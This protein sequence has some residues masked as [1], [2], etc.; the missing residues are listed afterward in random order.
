MMLLL[1]KDLK[2]AVDLHF[3]IYNIKIEIGLYYNIIIKMEFTLN[4]TLLVL[5]ENN[6]LYYWF[7]KNGGYKLKNPYWRLKETWIDNGYFCCK[8]N[9]KRYLFHRV[10]YYAYNQDW[11]IEDSSKD[12]I[13]DHIDRDT[14]NNHISNLRRCNN[15]VNMLNRQFVDNAKGYRIRPNGKFEVFF[16]GKTQGTCDTEDEAHQKYLNVKNEYLKE[17]N[18]VI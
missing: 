2:Q 6:D 1:R 4:D 5:C 17:N 18:I 3:K 7:D 9:N 11:N 15:S 14:T 16:R 13:L 8:I 10:V 12:N